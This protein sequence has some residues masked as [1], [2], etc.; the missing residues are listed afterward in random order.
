MS[1]SSNPLDDDDLDTMRE[2]VLKGLCAYLNEDPANLVWEFVARNR[3]TV[4][5]I[6]SALSLFD[7][8]FL[9]LSSLRDL[10]HHERQVEEEA[11]AQ[12]EA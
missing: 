7:F 2:C 5:S 10:P 4:S 8:L 9:L 11:Y 3:A 1:F 12:T 6:N